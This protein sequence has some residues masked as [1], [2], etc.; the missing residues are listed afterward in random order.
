MWS[1][2]SGQWSVAAALAAVLVLAANA[3]A[4]PKKELDQ[5]QGV[6]KVTEAVRDGK[7]DED[8]KGDTLT[9]AGES[10]TI[11]VSKGGDMKGN[12]KLDFAKKPKAVDLVNTDGAAKGSTFL[13]IYEV[14]GETMKLC[15]AP[16]AATE[17][18]KEFVSK[19]G[20]N[21]MM[22]TLKREKK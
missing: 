13:G 12:L 22:I 4:D 10:F 11:K 2:V 14:A 8:I 15:L 7:P 17:R 16:P 5:L 18:P 19:P 20:A 21:H 9:I 1:V 6:W 3:Q